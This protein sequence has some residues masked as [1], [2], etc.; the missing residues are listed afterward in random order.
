[1]S[2][3]SDLTAFFHGILDRSVM[4][5]ETEVLGWL[6]PSSS[7]GS[8]YNLVGM[9]WEI[10]REQNLTPNHPH[11]IDLYGKGGGAAGY[12]SQ[13]TVIDEYG[14][15]VVLLTAGSFKAAHFIHNAV[16][17]TLIPV[18]DEIARE[19]AAAAFTGTYAGSQGESGDR[20][21]VTIAQDQNSLLLEQLDRNGKDMLA[22][23]RE[24]FVKNVG[25][26]L[27]LL[28]TVARI[29]PADLARAETDGR[30]S[31]VVREEWRLEWELVGNDDTALPGAD[32]GKNDCWNWVTG[33]WVYYASQS[34][35][36]IILVKDAST[37]KVLGVELPVLRS[38]LLRKG[39][40]PCSR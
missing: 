3:L 16:L 13:A 2:T 9:P 19:Q 11:T 6:K 37:G 33:D 1:V 38:G 14:I 23:Y 35:D 27:D 28:P 22:S 7:T 29:Y 40:S 31:S 26:T 12:R 20:I 8:S 34:M 18:V 39:N 21:N 17:K 5:T 32:L 4:P 24:L 15:A 30:N 10:N 25:E 36:R